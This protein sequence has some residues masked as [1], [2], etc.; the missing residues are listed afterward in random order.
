MYAGHCGKTEA[1]IK[2]F[3]IDSLIENSIYQWL[4]I[5]DDDTLLRSLFLWHHA[6]VYLL[7]SSTYAVCLGC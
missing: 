2:K 5:A 6:E 1:I 3:F 4:V 7:F